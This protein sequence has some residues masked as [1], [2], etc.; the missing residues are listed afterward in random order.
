MSK[1]KATTDLYTACLKLQKKIVTIYKGK[2]KNENVCDIHNPLIKR[3][4]I[5]DRLKEDKDDYLEGVYVYKCLIHDDDKSICSI[6][7]CCGCR[8]EFSGRNISGENYIN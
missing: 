1:R 7:D 6:Y 8:T 5:P 2:R 4:T 3:C